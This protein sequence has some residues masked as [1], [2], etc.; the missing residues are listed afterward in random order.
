MKTRVYYGEYTLRHWLNL[1]L[2]GHIEL[3][4]YQRHF[5]WEQKNL[6]EL[7][8]SLKNNIYIPPITI[9]A[10]KDASGE[11]H[12]YILDGQQRLTSVLLAYIGLFPKKK[13]FV[14]PDDSLYEDSNETEVVL[15]N[16]SE[17]TRPI[18]WK[19][20]RILDLIS[21]NS[22]SRYLLKS[23]IC[24]KLATTD[25]F[26]KYESLGADDVIDEEFIQSKFLGFS[27]I[28]PQSANVQEQQNFY[29]SVFRGLNIRGLRLSGL[30]SRRALYFLN[31][32]LVNFFDIPVC[33][34]IKVLI[35]SKRTQYDFVRAL[36]FIAEYKKKGVETNIARGCRRQENL[37][38]Y[39]EDYI[40]DVVKDSDSAR[41][42]KFSMIVPPDQR[43]S[44]MAN[45]THAI[46]LLNLKRNIPTIIEA[47]LY[48]FGLVYF[49]I[50]EGYTIDTSLVSSIKAKI[51][52]VVAEIKQD[53]SHT[54]TP[55]ALGHIRLRIKQSINAY[56]TI[57]DHGTI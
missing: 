20:T 53:S 26:T 32:D 45:L 18:L 55:N 11:I 49:T 34:Q 6:H 19:Y 57:L 31:I 52:E 39:Y 28:V 23:D 3:P 9:G 56:Q 30:E 29:S 13:E 4:E 46:D 50:Y 16:S 14:E 25:D 33:K 15:D 44:R 21:S 24:A 47:D 22:G 27:Y 5:A 43:E 38:Q 10:Y 1:V 37:E 2:K 8:M 12:N 35:K 36:A 42:G 51:E 17:E 48:M 7:I 40:N 54:R 41:F